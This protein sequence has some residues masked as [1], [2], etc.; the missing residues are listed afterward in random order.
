MTAR[1]ERLFVVSLGH[2]IRL[3]R[4]LRGWT[5]CQLAERAGMAPA[6]VNAIE[7]GV[8]AP[9]I[10]MVFRLTAALRVPWIALAERGQEDAARLLQETWEANGPLH[11]PPEWSPL[12]ADRAEGLPS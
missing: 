9:S 10:V 7:L 2:R 6:T 11:V 5:T 4:R 8:R 12:I 3:L 1:A